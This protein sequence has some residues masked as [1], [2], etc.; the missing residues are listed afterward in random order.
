MRRAVRPPSHTS[1]GGT[2]GIFEVSALTTGVSNDGL[3]DG[4]EIL[5]SMSTAVRRTANEVARMPKAD[6]GGPAN[7]RGIR[8]HHTA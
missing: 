6:I 3:E 1:M 4:A 2:G 7:L 5:D 8:R